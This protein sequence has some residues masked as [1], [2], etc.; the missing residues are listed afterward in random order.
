[1]AEVTDIT[2]PSNEGAFTVGKRDEISKIS[3]LGADHLRLIEGPVTATVGTYDSKGIARLTPMWWGADEDFIHINTKKHRL[4]YKN[5]V[6]RPEVS[7]QAIDPEDPYH[8]ITVYG[9]VADVVAEEDA[10]RGHLATESIDDFSETY[11]GQSPYPF[12]EDDEIRVL[13]YI[14]ADKIVTFGGGS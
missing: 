7:I 10:E 9:T 13:F 8:W 3:E 1:M 2:T 4:K 5:L 6:D 14:R 12:R 11:L